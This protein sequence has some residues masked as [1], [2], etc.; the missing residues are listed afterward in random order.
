MFQNEDL[1]NHIETSSTIKTR[2]LV[3]A[4]WNLNRAEN[5][6][7]IGNYRYRPLAGVSEQYG[8]MPNSF[9]VNDEGNYYTDA[10]YSDISIDGGLD[11]D[12]STPLTF[13][14]RE[15]KEK[16]LFSLEDCFDRFRPRSGINKLRWFGNKYS[17]YTNIDMARRPRYYMP[18]K[19]DQFKYWTSF[20]KEVVGENTIERGIANDVQN[21]QYYIDDANPYVVYKESIPANRIVVKLQTNVGDIDQGPFVNSEGTYNDPFFGESNKT[22]P[23]DWKIQY[24]ENDNW[25]DAISFDSTSVRSN[26]NPIFGN[27]GY[28]QIDYGLIIPEQYRNIIIFADEV[29][30]TSLLPEQAV[31]GYA[32][33]VK[34]SS[35][36]IGTY[37]IWMGSGYEQFTP[38]YGWVVGEEGINPTTNFIKDLV[39][40]ASF[41]DPSNNN[42]Q[43]RDFQYIRGIR[44]VTRTMNTQD[45]T[46]DLIEM[47]P[48]LAADLSEKV[49]NFSIKKSAS[50]LGISGMPVGQ[51]LAST[52]SVSIFDYDQSFESQNSNSII[53]DFSNRNL[54]IKFYEAISE[55]NGYDYFVPIKTMYASSF[56]E[57]NSTSREVSIDLRD[58]FLYFESITAPQIL[59]QNA[60]VSYAIS[61][62]LDAIGFS[63]YTFKRV[64]GEDEEIIPYFFIPPDTTVAQVLNDIAVSTQ[65]AMFFDEYN[66]F[67]MMSKEYIMPTT[68]DRSTDVNLYGT[69]DFADQGVIENNTTNPKLANIMDISFQNTDV[70]NAGSINYTTRYIQRSVGTIK[71]ASM[72][73]KDRVW[74][75]KPALLWEVSPTQSTKS[76]NGDRSDQ[77][78]YVLS[79]IPLNS[80]LTDSVP[81]VVNNKIVN[82]T[83]D[84]GEGVYWL[85]R[86]YGYFYANGE[87]IKFDAVQ[88]SIPSAQSISGE[89]TGTNN[90]WISSNQEYQKYFS[91][92]PFNGKMYPTGLVRIYAEPN[93]ETV[94]GVTSLANGAVAKH[95]RGQFETPVVYH[96]AGLDPYWSDNTN[97]RGCT[98]DSNYLFNFDSSL[99]ASNLNLDTQA[100]GVSNTLATKTT[101]NGIIKNFLTNSFKTE[102]E[103]NRLYSTETGTIQ[104]SALIMNGPSFSTTDRPIDFVS[105]VHKPL[106]NK[107]KHFGTRMRIIG[108]IENSESRGQTGIG[109]TT[110]FVST[111]ADPSLSVNIGGSSGG[112]AVMINPETNAGYY[113]EIAA[114]SATNLEAYENS[115][116][117]NNVFFYKVMR[118]QDSGKAVP[119]KLYDGIA[120]IIVDDGKFTGQYRMSAETNPTVYDLAVE[121]QDIGSTRR[122]FLYINNRIVATVDDTNPL[123]L[124]SNMALFVRG[125]SRCMFENIYALTNNYSQNTSYALDTPINK[126]FDKDEEIDVNESFRK[127]SMSGAI[128]ASYLSGIG[129]SSPPK[130]NM[131]FEEFGTI[132]REAAYFDVRYD[133]AYPAL[134]AKLSPTFNK[135][136]GY[137]TSGFIAG[138]YG[139]EFLIF[140][141]TD[142]ALSLDETTGNYLRIQ[143]VTFTQQSQN[144]LTVDEY[145]EKVGN[146]SD[147]QFEQGDSLLISPIKTKQQY[148]DI[149]F[150]RM[151]NGRKEFSLDAKYLQSDDDAE[152]LMG[153][154]ISKTMKPRKSVGIRLFANPMIQL[155]DVVQINYNKD[156]VDQILDSSSRFVVYNISYTKSSGG[157]EMEIYLSEVV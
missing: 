23:V 103:T 79:A 67:V 118:D 101:R 78:S 131:Y 141:A 27:D 125:S 34:N 149:K 129:P 2:S 82:N 38:R 35:T 69:T 20:R 22:V 3:I 80:D 57:T 77:S 94:D 156:G 137:T 72:I 11:D 107:F 99:D 50:D 106:T 28:L 95:G 84:L 128:Q 26:G 116:N 74:T 61:M 21:N 12:N 147:P 100:A 120:N 124:Y 114:L 121:Y 133:K 151:T 108:K 152:K 127:Y 13:I 30:S 31:F 122:F 59:I 140:N 68:E 54:Q 110:Y 132:M 117:I 63:N 142:T 115:E 6:Y 71:Q 143:G 17:H 60:S 64:A 105:Y 47:S 48:R 19:D 58:M 62:L 14:S 109:S 139:A 134:Y 112:L 157:P 44:I 25:I 136:K 18:H 73:D 10:T 148:Q 92:I 86:Y 98:M 49:V 1:L 104:S 43:Y 85:A 97:V 66:N 40:P 51:L 113:F 91:K 42:T 9:D 7:Q 126:V 130:Y 37:H 119:V 53:K 138:A 93:Y 89:T 65:T 153:W 146:L 123:P 144:E 52:G 36:D 111:T 83:M 88:Y 135:I 70:Y 5:I 96:N 87:V 46:L 102:S 45:A 90:V 24:L 56:E 4:E 41:T 33:L 55:V 76:I 29:S 150:S 8:T 145:F 154:L 32:Y 75:Y 81:S 39:S 16:I 15:Q 155:G